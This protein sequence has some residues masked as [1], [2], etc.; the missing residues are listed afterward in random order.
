VGNLASEGLRLCNVFVLNFGV[1][2][3]SVGV[4]RECFV[5]PVCKPVGRHERSKS[6]AS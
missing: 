3:P 1:D 6:C 4:Y 5:R 2:S